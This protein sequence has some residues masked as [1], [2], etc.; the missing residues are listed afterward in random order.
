[1][2]TR[3]PNC[4]GGCCCNTNHHNHSS[5]VK[6]VYISSGKNGLLRYN[7]DWRP[8]SEAIV[9]IAGDGEVPECLEASNRRYG[10]LSP[11]TIQLAWSELRT[12][13][14]D[15][16]VRARGVRVSHHLTGDEYDRYFYVSREGVTEE[17]PQSAVG[18]CRLS[19]LTI[20]PVSSVCNEENSTFDPL[21]DESVVVTWQNVQIQ[22]DEFSRCFL[23]EQ[24]VQSSEVSAERK[25]EEFLS[26]VIENSLETRIH[27]KDKLLQMAREQVGELSRES[28][29][30]ARMRVLDRLDAN[31]W[32]SPGR[33]EKSPAKSTNK[34]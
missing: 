33:P 26:S 19:G 15:G 32:K 34:K 8:I 4:I 30:R 3:E 27:T 23:A 12:A 31:A 20:E 13:I 7:G 5:A 11:Q 22:W 16:V 17:V 25:C 9:C 18:V 24:A 6:D 1:M 2:V 28:F 10:E 29:E 21:R 14:T